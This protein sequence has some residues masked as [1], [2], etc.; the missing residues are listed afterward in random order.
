MPDCNGADTIHL[1]AGTYQLAIPGGSEDE[2]ATGDLD[3]EGS[4]TVEGRGRAK[5]RIVS[6]GSDRT[7]D[8]HG[9]S[10]VIFK[11][12]SIIGRETLVG[13]DDYWAGGAIQ[14]VG[15]DLRIS[16][17]NVSGTASNPPV[18]ALCWSGE[19]GAI[20]AIGGG[21]LTIAR[22]TI[23]GNAGGGGG[24]IFV[25]ETFLRISDSDLSGTAHAAGESAVALIRSSEATIDRTRVHD[26]RGGAAIQGCCETTHL[27]VRASDISD[28][29]GAG[30][31]TVHGGVLEVSDTTI[32]G[33]TGD[34]SGYSSTPAGI[35]GTWFGDSDTR[36]HRQQRVT[37][38]GGGNRPSGNA[39]NPGQRYRG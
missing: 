27:V 8:I 28:N 11:L 3:V 5:T 36:F 23:T 17:S 39:D 1:A 26:S 34:P 38:R 16:K 9:P 2:S 10:L 6:D 21:S 4:L 33:N 20:S 12:L 37:G 31:I 32:T 22:S 15:A 25:G 13:A 35:G 29:H 7:F 30:G 18:C 19:G 24:A 14:S